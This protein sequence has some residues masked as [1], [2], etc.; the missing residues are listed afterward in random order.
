MKRSGDDTD[1]EVDL[2][3]T[4]SFDYI[5]L[6]QCILENQFTNFYESWDTDFRDIGVTIAGQTYSAKIDQH[7][8]WE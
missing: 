7:V 8:S 5:Q 4:Y 6:D 1:F 2:G 3:A